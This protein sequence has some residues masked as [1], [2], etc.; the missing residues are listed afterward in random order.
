MTEYVNVCMCSVLRRGGYFSA[1]AHE[2][3]GLGALRGLHTGILLLRGRLGLEIQISPT[4][5][6]MLLTCLGVLAT[7]L[8]LQCARG[9]HH[10]VVWMLH[11]SH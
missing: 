9:N 3:I 11:G 6:T 10:S 7:V 8:P 1:V 2:Y 5:Q 4:I